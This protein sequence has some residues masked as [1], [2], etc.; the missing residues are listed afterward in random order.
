M[1]IQLPDIWIYILNILIWLFIHL[2]IAYWATLLP[3]EKFIKNSFFL[4]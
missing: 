3:F 2:T 4:K 1:L